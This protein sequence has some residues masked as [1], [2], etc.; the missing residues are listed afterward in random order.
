MSGLS[1]VEEVMRYMYVYIYMYIY[2]CIY[3]YIYIY[4]RVHN[5][6]DILYIM[7]DVT[8]FLRLIV[9]CF[10]G[11]FRHNSMQSVTIKL[12]CNSI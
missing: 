8:I 5:I 6:S 7:L 9:S 10:M 4:V 2:I 12:Q 3:I 1:N 11:I